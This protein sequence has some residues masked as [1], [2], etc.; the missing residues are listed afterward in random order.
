LI[1]ES[2]SI[3]KPQNRNS[4]FGVAS[5]MSGLF[6]FLIL[7]ISFGEF[8]ALLKDQDPFYT[9]AIIFHLLV[10]MASGMTGMILGG[11]GLIQTPQRKTLAVSGLILGLV[12]GNLSCLSLLGLLI[13]FGVLIWAAIQGLS[14]V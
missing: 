10:G 8:I 7:L 9:V 5:F 4:A 13:S 6:A 2:S 1:K 12:G 3:P 14:G 11:V